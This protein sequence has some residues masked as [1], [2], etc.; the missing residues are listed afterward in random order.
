VRKR[1]LEKLAE[2][3]SGRD[4]SEIYVN[5]GRGLW[6][7][8]RP[9]A[10]RLYSSGSGSR[11]HINRNVSTRNSIELL[12]C[13][14][15]GLLVLFCVACMTTV[16]PVVVGQ[17]TVIIEGAAWTLV[18]TS[19]GGFPGYPK[20]GNQ[21]DANTGLEGF[22]MDTP[23]GASI[24]IERQFAVPSVS[25]TLSMTV[26]GNYDPVT[27]TIFVNGQQLDTFT[28]PPTQKG[29]APEI[30]QYDLSQWAGQAASIRISQTSEYAT[31]TFCWYKN[32]VVT[33]RQC[34]EGA[35]KVLETCPDG[36]TWRHRQVCRNNA[37]SD[38]YQQCPTPRVC[39]E[40]AVNV[41]QT[42][43]DGYTWNHRQVCRNNAWHDE[44]QQCPTP[45]GRP[46]TYTSYTIVTIAVVILIPA[47]FWYRKKKSDQRT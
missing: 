36:Y 44:Y 1:N 28:P 30:K 46:V 2:W 35:V 23:G 4:Y 21:V 22:G 41:L 20:W 19:Q 32:I 33:G 29:G 7:F 31:G 17:T 14:V 26:W 12:R 11:N 39:S 43:P 40:G 9:R 27:V 37:W 42:C 5:C 18:V 25:P 13:E 6:L 16:A 15:V 45:P 24:Y 10:N 38:E 8:P 34:S 47:V 3:F